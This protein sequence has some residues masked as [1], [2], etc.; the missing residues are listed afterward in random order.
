M[1]PTLFNCATGMFPVLEVLCPH[2]SAYGLLPESDSFRSGRGVSA[3]FK[4]TSLSTLPPVY[5]G[6][7]WNRPS[8]LNQSFGK[9]PFSP[10]GS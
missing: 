5:V 6:A 3:L 7:V 8:E 1:G 4:C 2:G 10:V 9:K